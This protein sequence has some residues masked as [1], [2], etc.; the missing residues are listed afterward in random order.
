MA[1]A[2]EKEE[3]AFDRPS[4]IRA[5]RGDKTS[6]QGLQLFATMNTVDKAVAR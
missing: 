6:K 5:D 2:V 4:P 3:S 1:V